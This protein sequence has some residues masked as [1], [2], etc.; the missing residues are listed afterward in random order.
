MRRYAELTRILGDILSARQKGSRIRILEVGTW[1]GVRAIELCR[2]VLN[3]GFEVSY[4]GI[5]LFEDLTDEVKA[6]EFCGKAKPPSQEEVLLAIRQ[7]VPSADVIIHKGRSHAVLDRLSGEWT[8]KKFD[9]VFIDGGHSVETIRSDFAL[10]CPMVADD[11]VLVMD[12]YYMERDDV[13][14]QKVVEEILEDK[15]YPKVT[16]VLEPADHDPNTGLTIHLVSV[17]K[18]PK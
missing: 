16:T 2:F 15:S 9:L 6:A 12:D 1:K 8:E 11:G 3:R 14:C 4:R 10:S 7:E 13:G 5:D 17:R 18:C